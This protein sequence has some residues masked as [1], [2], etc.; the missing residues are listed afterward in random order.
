[1]LFPTSIFACFFAIVF[2]LHWALPERGIARKLALLA[3]SVFFYA[4]WSWKF[5][6]MLLASAALNHAAAK[7]AAA[8]AAGGERKAQGVRGI[9]TAAVV[10]NLALLAFFKYS[11]FLFMD[12]FHPLAAIFCNHFGSPD[13][14]DGL[15]GFEYDRAFPFLNGIILPIGISFY[16]FQAISYV[17]DCASGKCR[18]AASLLDFANYLAFFPKLCAGPITRPADIIPQMEVLPPRSAPIDTGRAATLVLGGLLK[19]VV[20]A[21]WLAGHLADPFFTDPES[22]GAADAL[23]G[24]YGYTLQIY[25]DFSAYSDIATGCA[26]MLGFS[27]PCNFRAPYLATSLQDFWRRWHITLSSWLRDYLY[28]PLGG[29]RCATWKIHRNLI[30]TMLLGGLWHGAGW[31]YIVWGAIHGVG[32]SLERPFNRRRSGESSCGCRAV[33]FIRALITFHIVA[34]AWIFFRA[35]AAD[36]EGLRT[37]RLVLASLADFS[38]PHAL[39]SPLAFAFLAAAFALQAL[40]GET[41]RRLQSAFSN[42]HPAVQGL[43]AALLLTAILGLGPSGV[44]PFIYFQF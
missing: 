25:C 10:A 18:P 1:M 13:M 34:F 40:D 4:W 3:A 28:I 12:V 2:A 39:V 16:T 15:I 26:L 38:S 7:A 23:L 20:V 44:A 24:I 42:L 17:L 27:F 29:S 22:Y 36:A 14:L 31:S 8:R 9:V 41:P 32:Q 35:G 19:K 33:A 21:N 5:A 30:L 37:V 6:I 43:L 11:S